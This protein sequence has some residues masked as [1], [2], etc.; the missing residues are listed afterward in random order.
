MVPTEEDESGHHDNGTHVSDQVCREPI[1]NVVF[2]IVQQ[3]TQC[4]I[5]TTVE[6]LVKVEKGCDDGFQVEFHD[7]VD[8]FPHRRQKILG[9]HA[10]KP[11]KD[12]LLPGGVLYVAGV[13]GMVRNSRRRRNDEYE[14]GG[15]PSVP[16]RDEEEW[17]QIRLRI[18]QKV[19]CASEYLSVHYDTP[20]IFAHLAS[21]Y[22]TVCYVSETQCPGWFGITRQRVRPS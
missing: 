22:G 4:S 1:R 2:V 17:G 11:E 10:T 7:R 3:L 13:D 19:A 8:Q 18:T 6:N 16:E 14:N 15:L 5:E 20:L 21:R 12:T 9:R